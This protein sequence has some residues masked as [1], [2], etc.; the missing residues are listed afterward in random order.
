MNP[1][2][3]PDIAATVSRLREEIAYHEK[4]YYVDNDPQISDPEFDALMTRLRRLEEQHPELI[5]PESPTQRVGEKPSEGFPTVRHRVPMMSLDNVFSVEEFE[6]FDARTRKLL[7]G[8]IVSYTAELKIDGLSVSVLYRDGRLAQAVTRG[9]GVQGDDV[10]GNAR[11]IRS[12]PLT[13][14]D[15][16]PIEVRGKSICPSLPSGKSTRPGKS[17]GIPCLPI[18]ETP[19]PDRSGFSIPER[20]RSG[21]WT[22]SSIR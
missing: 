6:E 8:R 20:S 1:M 9:D 2:G 15:R 5:V 16:R 4:K 22:R 18:R 19:R 7:S 14:T 10:T 21:A 13:I 17:A 12:L 11:T 3:G